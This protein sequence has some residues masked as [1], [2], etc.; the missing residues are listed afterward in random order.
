[1]LISV[2]AICLQYIPDKSVISDFD[3]ILA[4]KLIQDYLH[5][6]NEIEPKPEDYADRH[7]DYPM[8]PNERPVRSF[9]KH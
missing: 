7:L 9:L 3:L 8:Y 5:A 2:L 4:S 1:M 6:G